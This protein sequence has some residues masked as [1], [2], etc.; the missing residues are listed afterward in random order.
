MI[1]VQAGSI[2]KTYKGKG[3]SF[4]IVSAFT[5][6]KYMKYKL[7]RLLQLVPLSEV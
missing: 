4:K 6:I 3:I 5:E 7:N 1:L 2:I